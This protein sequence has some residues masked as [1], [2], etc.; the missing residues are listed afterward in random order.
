[1][2]LNEALERYPIRSKHHWC[3]YNEADGSVRFST[4]I[5]DFGRAYPFDPWNRGL[6]CNPEVERDAEGEVQCWNYVTTLA[7]NPVKLTIFND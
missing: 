3:R 6:P 7:G 2:T 5:S 1:M 4:F